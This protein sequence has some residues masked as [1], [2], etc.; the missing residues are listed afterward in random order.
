VRC[1]E[2]VRVQAYFDGELDA[3]ASREVE[4]HVEQCGD[5]AEQLRS[6]GDA[7]ERLRQE[8]P[9][10]RAPAALRSRIQRALDAEDAP[11]GAPR[12]ARSRP[13]GRLSPFWRGGLSG[14][15]ATLAAGAIAFWMLALP[16]ANPVVE[17]VLEAHVHSLSSAH[18]MDVV[19]TDKHTVKP[20]FAGH[21]DVAPTVTDFAS[22]GYTL[23]GG[24][25]DE[26]E[27]QRAAVLVYQHGAHIVN[28]FCWVAPRRPLP[29]NTTR[30]GYH[31]AFWRS[32]DLAYAAVSDTDWAELTALERLMR[33]TADGGAPVD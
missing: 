29:G 20:W 2:S 6:L 4:R 22:D 1:A 5:C 14:A 10:F 3:G 25:V 30:H 23:K 11:A 7:R 32:A 24:R 18:L 8:L 26:F 28:V 17:A 27:H 9:S 12:P 19:S 15:G 16:V 33:R 31:M 13:T 21:A